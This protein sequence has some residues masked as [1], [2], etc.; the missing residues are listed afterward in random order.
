MIGLRLDK[1]LAHSGYGTRKEVKTLIRKG[2]VTVDGI[3][4]RKDDYKIRATDK[5]VCV[6]GVIVNYKQYVYFMLNKPQGYVS[7]TEDSYYPVVTDLIVGYEHMDLFPV[8]RLDIDTEGLLLITN[9]GELAH[10]LLSPKKH[11][12]KKYYAVIDGEVTN[13]DVAIFKQGI[14][15]DDW[16]TLP[17]NLE[18]LDVSNG[19][20]DIIV[21]IYEGKF[22]QVKRMFEAVGKHV[23]YLQRIQM[24][25]LK[26]D[27]KLL[28][29]DY[30]ELTGE[31]LN[32][33]K[34]VNENDTSC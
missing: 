7:A 17:A 9:D 15:I 26:L 28:L 12:S 19:K 22:H 23:E 5:E 24:K 2:F 4:I 32:D 31:E 1:L 21:E 8:G 20:S 29:G 34:G 27:K 10:Q 25:N 18:I 30:R 16:V 3:I 33:L 14:N 11:V 13:D 6:D